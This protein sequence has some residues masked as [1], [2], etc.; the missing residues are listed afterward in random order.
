MSKFNGLSIADL[1]RIIEYYTQKNVE[2]EASFLAL[3]ITSAN[4][5]KDLTQ[6]YYN[7]K[8][9]ITI[10]HKKE[11]DKINEEFNKKINKLE[12]GLNKKNKISNKE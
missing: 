3:Q 1:T 5:E 6:K 8:N 9:E 12:S 10:T 2:L 11:L 4:K 7:E